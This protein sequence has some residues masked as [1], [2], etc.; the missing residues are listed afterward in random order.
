MT[1]RPGERD[2]VDVLAHREEPEAHAAVLGVVAG[3]ELLL[4]LGQVER[5]AGGLGGAGEH[6]DD[7][8]DELRGDVP[9]VALRRDDL[10]Q[11][12]RLRH[13]HDAEH[14]ERERDLVADELRAG[15]HRAE[16]RVLRVGRPA[17]DDEA[18]DPDRADRED[19][20]QARSGRRRPGPRRRSRRSPSRGR[21]GSRRRSR[22][23]RTRPRTATRCRGRR[24]PS[25]GRSSPSGSASSGRRSAAG[26]R[27]GRRGSA[28]SGAAS[29]PSP[30]ARR[31]S[32]TRTRR[33]R[34]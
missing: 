6:E 33:G 20:D 11:R 12:E 14:G 2:Q 16:Q 9:P 25:R 1:A 10:G 21:T 31:A 4:G 28:R 30:S 15:A 24:P 5:R 26:A 19:Q 23:P 8:A 17:A 3:D 18:V 7:E 22:A 32:G 29:G 27:T 34:G 13:D